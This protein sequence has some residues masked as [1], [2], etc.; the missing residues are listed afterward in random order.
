MLD[1]CSIEGQ[2]LQKELESRFGAGKARFTHCDV[3]C[4]ESLAS[5]FGSCF[6]SPTSFNI[7]HKILTQHIGV[8]NDEFQR[9]RKL[10]VAKAGR[11]IFDPFC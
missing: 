7:A 8:E 11:A 1:I 4:K 10:H 5:K 3:S 9:A 6:T 2:E